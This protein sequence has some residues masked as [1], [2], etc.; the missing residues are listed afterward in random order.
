[1]VKHGG[2]FK[3]MKASQARQASKKKRGTLGRS[4]EDRKKRHNE[5]VQYFAAKR[6][7]DQLEELSVSS[8]D[9]S[10]SSD[11]DTN[12]LHAKLEALRSSL[13]CSKFPSAPTDD[14]DDEFPDDE[15]D[16]P[17]EH[18]NDAPHD[19]DSEEGEE[20]AEESVLC[21]VCSKDLGSEQQSGFV[22]ITCKE[23][24]C[25]KCFHA[26]HG[27]RT[28][29]QVI[30]LSEVDEGAD[31]APEEDDDVDVEEEMSNEDMEE[32]SYY[33]SGSDNESVAAADVRLLSLP[34]NTIRTS[35]INDLLANVIDAKDIWY[36]KYHSDATDDDHGQLSM[37][38]SRSANRVL[39]TPRLSKRLSAYELLALPK[40][41][42]QR[43]FFVHPRV[44]S[45]WCKFRSDTCVFTDE[46]WLSFLRLSTYADVVDSTRTWDSDHSVIEISLLH[47]VNHFYKARSVVALHNQALRARRMPEKKGKRRTAAVDDEDDIELRDRGFGKTRILLLLPMRNIALRYVRTLVKMLGIDESNVRNFQ[48]F[49][50][51]FSEVDELLDPN[52]KRRPL[53]YRRQFEGNINDSFCFGLSLSAEPGSGATMYS[54]VLNSDIVIASPIGLRNRIQKN[55][56]ALVGL[57]SIEVCIVD[58]ASVLLMQNWQHVA[59]VMELLNAPPRDTTEGLSDL[60]RVYQWALDGKARSKRQTAIFAEWTNAAFSSLQRRS[61]NSSGKIQVSWPSFEGSLSKVATAVRQH[62]RRFDVT[63]LST[64]DD[65]R[66]DFFVKK[67]FPSVIQPAVDRQVRTIIFVP[68]YFDFVR[69]RNFLYST[70]R[71]SFSSLS[72]YTP[73]KTQRRVL[74]QFSANERP[75]LVMTERFYF[76]KRYFVKMAESLLFYSPP[77]NPQ[78]Y[79][80]LVGKLESKS[81]SSS[82]MCLYSKIDSHELVRIVGSARAPQLLAGE[83]D[84]YFF[85]TS[86]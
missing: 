73:L 81:P 28:G 40:G 35:S 78:F 30:S 17:A 44:W 85:V 55:A 58:Q 65:E 24:F 80:L 54:H 82:V 46:E 74:G 43:P 19:G 41:Q 14:G 21:G 13:G 23:T 68:S 52:F 11:D 22:C 79:W 27:N 61:I 63:D 25:E 71:E 6:E 38:S 86:S 53:D 51:D 33:D 18:S 4:K 67:I 10:E 1:M 32:A 5:Q 83:S 60:T 62:F 2:F 70:V 64:A 45:A 34:A 69:V 76:F 37:I 12:P 16:S 3:R 9:S 8:T 56:D 36:Q 77:L 57:S 42:P 47:I 20:E 29:H 7:L 39:A 15:T 48:S 49:E 26:N 84:A 50:R 72:E 75:L 59:E 31:V 66:F